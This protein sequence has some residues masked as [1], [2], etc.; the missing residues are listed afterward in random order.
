MQWSAGGRQ[1]EFKK[2]KKSTFLINKN[3]REG[4][5]GSGQA[6]F[7]HP[8]A[9]SSFNGNELPPGSHFCFSGENLQQKNTSCSSLSNTH[10]EDK[11]LHGRC[12]PGK[13]RN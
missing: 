12:V 3:Q 9:A 10:E 2:T 13:A 4:S 5:G 8:A 7:Y 11:E 6:Q 1:E